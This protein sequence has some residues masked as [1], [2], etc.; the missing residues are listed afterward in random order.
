MAPTPGSRWSGG[1]G[2]SPAQQQN[3]IMV[4]AETLRRLAAEAR[5]E[6]GEAGIHDAP[7]TQGVRPDSG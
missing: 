6:R 7:Q 4:S 2:R 3:Y 1:A 5:A